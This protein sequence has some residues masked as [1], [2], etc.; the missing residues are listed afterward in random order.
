MGFLRFGRNDILVYGRSFALIRLFERR[1]RYQDA[2]EKSLDYYSINGI[3]PLPAV[4]RDDIGVGWIF[5]TN[6]SFRA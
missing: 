4:G 1:T 5:S 2:A 6:L 3:S